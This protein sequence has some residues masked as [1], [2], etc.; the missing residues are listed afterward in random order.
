MAGDFG[1]SATQLSNNPAKQ[2]D[3]KALEFKDPH[4]ISHRVQR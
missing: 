4:P 1:T 2:K 3:S